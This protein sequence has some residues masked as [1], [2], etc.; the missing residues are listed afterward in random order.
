MSASLAALTTIKEYM[1]IYLKC[2]C[3]LK[4]FNSNLFQAIRDENLNS[5]L[6]FQAADLGIA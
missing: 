5:F 3:L 4:R 2:C 1:M 6:N